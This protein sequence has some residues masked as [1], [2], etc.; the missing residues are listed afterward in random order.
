[1]SIPLW[2]KIIWLVNGH[3]SLARQCQAAR[4]SHSDE[5]YFP[6]LPFAVGDNLCHMRARE[7]TR[8]QPVYHHHMV[9]RR[10]AGPRHHRSSIRIHSRLELSDDTAHLI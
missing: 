4:V 10:V 6:T 8:A 5:Y 7:S 1:M 9:I 3:S 2:G